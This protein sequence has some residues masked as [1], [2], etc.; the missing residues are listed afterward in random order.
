MT[1]KEMADRLNGREYTN[2][3][4][5]NDT[6]D[7]KDSGLLICYG[8]SD[9]LLELCGV[10]NDEVSAYRGVSCDIDIESLEI[11]PTKDDE[12][13]CEKCRARAKFIT[14]N[15]QWCPKDL[16]T[17]WRITTLVPHETF[18]I[19]KDGELYC[20]GCVIELKAGGF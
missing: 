17:S 14:I 1:A 2:E 20:R 3:T 19:M 6:K 9:D 7:A 16:K 13:Y 11:M 8:A 4:D 18:D 15:A 12:G 10:I 5:A